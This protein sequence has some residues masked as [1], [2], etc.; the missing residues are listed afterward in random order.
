MFFSRMKHQNI[1][2]K[3]VIQTNRLL[4]SSE[5]CTEFGW[6]L[7]D[8]QLQPWIFVLH[9]TLLRTN[10][11]LLQSIRV[12]PAG[13]AVLICIIFTLWPWHLFCFGVRHKRCI[14]VLKLWSHTYTRWEMMRCL[15][16][17]CDSCKKW[18][19]AFIYNKKKTESCF[20][21][22]KLCFYGNSFTWNL[23]WDGSVSCDHNF[24]WRELVS[25]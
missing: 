8:L 6:R 2:Y 17:V 25:V 4:K 21:Q 11:V 20:H 13:T 3:T 5:N 19:S 1:N 15:W 14:L 18:F 24:V 23:P 10:T 7:V 16:D 12:L 22:W 9:S